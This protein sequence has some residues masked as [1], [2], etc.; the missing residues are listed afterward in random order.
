M[1]KSIH[2]AWKLTYLLLEMKQPCHLVLTEPE[3]GNFH[4]IKEGKL[5]KSRPSGLCWAPIQAHPYL[6]WLLSSS[7]SSADRGA[8]DCCWFAPNDELCFTADH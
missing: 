2:P 6:G 4:L 5:G 3:S 1:N 7:S 8:F